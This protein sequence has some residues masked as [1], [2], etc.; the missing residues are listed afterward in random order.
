MNLLHLFVQIIFSLIVIVMGVFTG[1]WLCMI[2]PEEMVKGK[3]WAKLLLKIFILLIFIVVLLGF[4]FKIENLLFV[5]EFI[6]F[7][8]A[9]MFGILYSK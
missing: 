8:C 4:F 2:A 6:L 5:V 9:M 7:L 3:K 1:K